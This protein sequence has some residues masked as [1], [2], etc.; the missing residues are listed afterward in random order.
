MTAT[1][2]V[3]LSLT[4][5]ALAALSCGVAAG[6]PREMATLAPADA[7]A[8]I[9]VRNGAGL[10]A[11]LLESPFWRALQV[12]EAYGRHL[13]SARHRESEARID[14]LLERLDMT[15]DEALRTY[16]GSRSALVI[17][18]PG[19]PPMGVLL[20]ET[21]KADAVKLVET[22]GAREAGTYRDVPTWEVWKEDRVDR[23]AVA[24][25]LL[26][27][28]GSDSDALERVLDVVAGEAPSLADQNA[29]GEAVGDLP[30]GWRVRAWTVEGQPYG[31]PAA[32]AL[33]P[34]R[35]GRLYAE[36]R[37]TGAPVEPIVNAPVALRSPG[38][39]PPNTVV[40]VATA[41]HAEDGWTVAKDRAAAVPEMP[42]A[43]KG[44]RWIEGAVR[45]WFPE[46]S[47]EE[48]AAAFGPEAGLA[49]LRNPEEG[50]PTLVGMVALREGGRPVADAFRS[51]LRRKAMGLALLTEGHPDAP[52]LDVYEEAVGQARM[53]VVEGSGVLL[54]KALGDWADEVALTVAVTDEWLIVGTAPSGVRAILERAEGLVVASALGPAPVDAVTRWG[55]VAPSEGSDTVLKL[56]SRMAGRDQL[57][58]ADRMLNLAELMTLVQGLTWARTDGAGVVRGRAEVQ[59]IAE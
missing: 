19:K 6:E 21:S 15:E 18:E 52:K 25:D 20:T 34:D 2:T 41:L 32:G 26:L 45:L 14:A 1:R 31:A 30:T 48:V 55:Y 59:A 49:L 24:G 47:V 53:L 42:R 56:A 29:F 43:K 35:D 16:L 9:E 17:T 3:L 22:L 58:K 40:A 13:G 10:R 44:V 39:L 51:S 8:L 11:M 33:Y 57:E 5:G 23:L 37:L 28:S 4:A 54:K 50:P 38:L 27:V 12:T 7:H 46:Q 36:W